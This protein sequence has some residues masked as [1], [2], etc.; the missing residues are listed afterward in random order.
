MPQC[1]KQSWALRK[2]HSK[3]ITVYSLTAK[4]LKEGIQKVKSDTTLHESFNL[5]I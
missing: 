2:W 4:L 1:I 5:N 3:L